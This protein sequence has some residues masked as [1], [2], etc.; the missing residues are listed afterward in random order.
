[1]R[2]VLQLA[3]VFLQNFCFGYKPNQ[4]LLYRSLSLFMQSTEDNVRR[5][6]HIKN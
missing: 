6:P 4:A 5:S 1:M 3:H 2:D